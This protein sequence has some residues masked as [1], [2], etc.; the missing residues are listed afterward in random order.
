MY[1]MIVLDM[2]DTLLDDNHKISDRNKNA[3]MKAQERGVYV[4]L[5]SGRP[6]GAM[7][8]YAKELKMDKYNSYIISFN[9]GEI[10]SCGSGE[11]IFEQ[12]LKKEE[13]HDLYDFSRE[14]K[15]QLIT[16]MDN[17]I[18]TEDTG[19]YIDVESTIT[20]MKQK[21]VDCFKSYVNRSAVKCIMLEEPE[22]LKKIEKELKEAKPD[23]SV[24]ISKPFFLEVMPKGIDKG[25]TLDR[26]AKMLDIDKKEI[27]AMGNAHNDL[28]MIEYSGLGVWVA[29]T[30]EE[31]LPL[32]DAVVAS[33]NDDGVAEAIEKYVL[34]L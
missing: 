33:N 23:K 18:I 6:S 32:G 4:V 19:K 30:N 17:M 20:K 12:S 13:I 5:A 25:H 29:N 34:T 21:K 9:G 2:D 16:Y 28:S 3:I 24:A 14:H 31:L 15:V 27:M 26:L 22:Y 8:E 10:I 7:I 11:V 1:K